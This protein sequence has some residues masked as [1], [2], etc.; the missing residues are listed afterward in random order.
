MNPFDWIKAAPW[1]ACVVLALALAAMTGKYLSKRDELVA[2][3]ASVRVLG[4]AAEAR[5]KAAKKESEDNLEKVK[6]DYEKQV[7]EIRSS[8]VASYLARRAADPARVR[9]P[10]A[11]GGPVS[12]DGAGVRVD[13]GTLKECVPDEEFIEDAAEDAAKVEA[14]R[15]YCALNHCPVE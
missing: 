2:L 4:E 13:D 15:S 3:T 8:A 1:I 6:A 5:V 10:V 14:W 9:E 7:P 12:G 11:G